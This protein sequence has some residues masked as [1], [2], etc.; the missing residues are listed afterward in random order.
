MFQGKLRKKKWK[1]EQLIR[2]ME[3]KLKN[4]QEQMQEEKQ[5]NSQSDDK[6]EEIVNDAGMIE[7]VTIIRPHSATC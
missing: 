5:E 4:E 7:H 3:K 6:S 1:E 2:A